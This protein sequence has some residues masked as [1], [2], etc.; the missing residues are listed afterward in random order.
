M[1]RKPCCQQA[2]L[3][4][5]HDDG[6][7]QISG[8]QE[9]QD[10]TCLLSLLYIDLS[11][12][13]V[14]VEMYAGRSADGATELFGREATITR[15]AVG[16]WQ[17]RF[18]TPHPDGDQYHP[19]LISEEES[20]L[21]DSPDIMVVQGTQNANGFDIQMTTGDNGG[22]ADA[23]VDAPWSFGVDAPCEV[24][25]DAALTL[26]PPCENFGDVTVQR[27]TDTPNTGWNNQVV[28]GTQAFSG[29]AEFSFTISAATLNTPQMIGLNSDP[30]TNAS[31]ATIDYALY[32]YVNGTTRRIYIYE[33]GAYRGLFF[34]PFALGDEFSIRRT[35]T[36][37]EYLRNDV[38]FYTSTVA[39][40]SDLY[41]DS[42]F[43]YAAGTWGSGSITLDGMKVCSI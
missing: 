25:A 34:N 21:R 13:T 20:N 1:A 14:Y 29:D 10:L 36:L 15:T 11:K 3:T 16:R 42:S 18:T 26:E 27:P 32:I 24:V 41:V 12:K 2:T 33:N 9:P 37:V 28:T 17:V 40:T 35:G 39:S 23:Y 4:V 30:A 5:N 19:S 22:A 43:Y 8:G 38:V 7:I 31:Y 6:T